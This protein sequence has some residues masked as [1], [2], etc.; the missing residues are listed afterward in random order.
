MSSVK[1][2]YV[3]RLI[4]GKSTPIN[5]AVIVFEGER[6]K[7]VGRENEVSVPN[8]ADVVDA[9]RYTAIPGLIDAHLH[10]GSNGEPD[11]LKTL[12][13]THQTL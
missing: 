10:L 3:G 11:L 13:K 1:V 6:I 9:S 8:K 5:N 4:D 7:A 2:I 12:V